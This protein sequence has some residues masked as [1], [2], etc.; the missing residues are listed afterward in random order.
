MRWAAASVANVHHIL[1]RGGVILYPQDTRDGQGTGQIALLHKANPLAMVIEQ[2]G[3]MASTGYVRISDIQP[4]SLH[5]KVPV[6]L[7]SHAE[8]QR[9]DRYHQEYLNGDDKPFSSPL[10]GTRTLFRAN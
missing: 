4:A 1:M 9:I 10:F 6:I 7:G 2:A 3:G 5:Q 8:I